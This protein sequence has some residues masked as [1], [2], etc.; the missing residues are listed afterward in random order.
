VVTA[1]RRV[2]SR[3][4]AAP[5]SRG[6]LT[7]AARHRMWDDGFDRFLAR[8]TRPLLRH[9]AAH[10]GATPRSR[11]RR[12]NPVALAP[13]PAGRASAQPFR[14]TLRPTIAVRH[15]AAGVSA[16][17]EPLQQR[18]EGPLARPTCDAR[19]VRATAEPGAR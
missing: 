9:G 8:D 2:R 12:L 18:L 3:V 16:A 1:R 7:I 13:R 6:S 19:T 4:R 17:S 11:A 14:S 10:F 5:D 15:E